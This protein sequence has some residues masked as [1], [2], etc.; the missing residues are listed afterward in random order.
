MRLRFVAETLTLGASA[1]S[2]LKS[3]VLERKLELLGLGVGEASHDHHGVG[4]EDA[5]HGETSLLD[6]VFVHFSFFIKVKLII[7]YYKPSKSIK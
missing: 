5:V 1:L 7:I 6:R 2:I 4:E 3:S